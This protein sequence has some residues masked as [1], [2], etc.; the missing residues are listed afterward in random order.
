MKQKIIDKIVERIGLEQILIDAS[1]THEYLA[2]ILEE[3]GYVD[4]SQYE[5]EEDY[6]G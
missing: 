4:L 6:N 2:M 5:H 1:I 3:S